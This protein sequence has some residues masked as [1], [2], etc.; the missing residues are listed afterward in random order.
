[1]AVYLELFHEFPDRF[2]TGTDF[3]AS[4]GKKVTQS[5]VIHGCLNMYIV[6]RQ[7]NFAQEVLLKERIGFL[8]SNFLM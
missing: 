4:F 1:M 7:T 6:G 8:K 3:V 5:I 2:L